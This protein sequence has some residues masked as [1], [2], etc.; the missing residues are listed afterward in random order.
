MKGDPS[1]ETSGGK[2]VGRV[3]MSVRGCFG[4]AVGL[5]YRARGRTL[6]SLES[7]LAREAEMTRKVAIYFRGANWS[8][9]EC[10]WECG[11]W[12][13]GDYLEWYR[14]TSSSERKC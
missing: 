14:E 13:G 1:V 11:W 6:F 2:S 8:G 9:V 10:G 5:G 12:G 7:L 3:D 4:V